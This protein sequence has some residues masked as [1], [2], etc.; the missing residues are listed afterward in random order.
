MAAGA[1]LASVIAI[2]SVAEAKG[3]AD[4]LLTSVYS[5]QHKKGE[6]PKTRRVQRR[7]KVVPIAVAQPS[8]K[9]ALSSSA[10]QVRA[11]E[12]LYNPAFIEALELLS[13]DY[14]LLMDDPRRLAVPRV[15][16]IRTFQGWVSSEE[17]AQ[18]VVSLDEARSAFALLRARILPKLPD[19]DDASLV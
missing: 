5:G 3:C 12:K 14:E 7:R 16:Y 10:V 17:P 2:P 19:S 9:P 11:S 4:R 1:A 15:L 8:A 18:I 13:V 6:I